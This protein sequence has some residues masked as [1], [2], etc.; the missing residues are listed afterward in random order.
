MEEETRKYK[1]MSESYTR[2][3]E[4]LNLFNKSGKNIEKET[5][6]MLINNVNRMDN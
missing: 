3:K 2:M 6:E 5:K 4:K 1:K